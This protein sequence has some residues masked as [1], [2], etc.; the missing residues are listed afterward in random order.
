[1]NDALIS[2]SW[3]I[4]QYLL[5]MVPLSNVVG[6]HPWICTQRFERQQDQYACGPLAFLVNMHPLYLKPCYGK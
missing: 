2:I 3:S 6:L 5:H 4:I 1:V